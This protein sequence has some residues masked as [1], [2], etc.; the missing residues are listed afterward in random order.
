MKVIDLCGEWEGRVIFTDKSCVVYR[1]TVPGCAINDLIS[2]SLLPKDI[3]YRDNAE[4]V[5]DFESCD[6][7]YKKTFEYSQDNADPVLRFERIDTY[8]DIFLNGKRIYHSENGN[9][10]HDIE[11]KNYLV[12]G[13][14]TLEVRLYSA[15]R[16]VKDM[17]TH[18]GAF[19]TERMNTRR[20]QCT[21]GWDWVARFL[22]SGIGEC[23]ILIPDELEIPEE[24]VYISTVDNDEESATVK[25]DITFCKEYKGRIFDFSVISPDGKE[26]CRLQKYCRES[27]VRIYFDIPAPRLWYPLGYGDQPLYTLVIKDEGTVKYSEKFGIR[28]V[29]IMQL[30]DKEGSEAYKLCRSIKNPDYDRNE[31]FSGF[32]VKINGRKVFCQGANWVPC[33]PYSMGNVDERQTEILEMCASFGV[34]MLRVWGGGAFETK[35]FYSECSRLG[36]MVTQDFLMACGAY[37]EEEDWFIEELRKEAEYVARLCRNQPCL[38]FWSGDNENAVRGSDLDES[39]RGRRSAY[40]GIAPILY[41][42]DPDRRFLPSSPFGGSFYASNTVGTTHNTQFLGKML[43]YLLSDDLSDYKEEFKKYRARFIA[44]EPQLGAVTLSSLKRFMTESDIYCAEEMWR[45]HMKSNPSL[46]HELYDYILNMT[47]KILGRFTD[48]RDKLFK[49]QYIQYEWIR[50]VFEQ[51]KRE[52]ALCSGIIFWMMNDCWPASCG[53]SLIDYYNRP[54]NA[55][56]SFKRCS[57]PI[58]SSIDFEDGKYRVYVINDGNETDVNLR[59][60]IVSADGFVVRP[61]DEI[62]RQVKSYSS[63]IVLEISE[64]LSSGETLVCDLFTEGVRDRSFYRHGALEMESCEVMLSMDTEA[65]TVSVLA[66][67]RYIHALVL[68][69]DAVFSDNCF[70]LLPYESRTVRFRNAADSSDIEISAE[71]Y[72]FIQSV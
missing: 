57:S 28:T 32:T 1:A 15:S 64:P 67:E 14:N 25:A 16:W 20:M 43:P 50:V 34:N 23:G 42:E 27:F 26:V 47:E 10:R 35:H 37:P 8:A 22:T 13:E 52:R 72:T 44:E 5:K 9:I 62:S 33:V 68:S 29:K 31:S 2:A 3:F 21:Y 53:W 12:R 19:T 58:I 17:P 61:V 18:S 24:N 66:G 40:E 63:S 69:G 54:K 56:Y 55:L 4:A 60:T 30:P 45:Y 36:I 7:L 39:Y 46:R 59:V 38:M 48:G 49:L 11:V 71:A 70:S 51:A 65:G 6:Y 41:R